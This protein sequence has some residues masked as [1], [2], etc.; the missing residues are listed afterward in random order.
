MSQV[1]KRKRVD[2]PFRHNDVR[3]RMV[4]G[5]YVNCEGR[6]SR[7]V[8]NLENYKKDT[9]IVET[10]N[11]DVEYMEGR[12]KV[13]K[14][15]GTFVATAAVTAA[16]AVAVNGGAV[17]K[18]KDYASNLWNQANSKISQPHV[19]PTTQGGS[20]QVVGY[21]FGDD[22]FVFEEPMGYTPGTSSRIVADSPVMPGNS[23]P[24]T[25]T[26]QGAGAQEEGV[27]GQER[28]NSG[29]QETGVSVSEY[30]NLT[31]Y[32]F[33][34]NEDGTWGF[35]SDRSGRDWHHFVVIDGYHYGND[36]K[37]YD[38]DYK[39]REVLKENANNMNTPR[40]GER[41]GTIA[42]T[43]NNNGSSIT[44]NNG[45]TTSVETGTTE[46]GATIMQHPNVAGV[47]NV[48]ATPGA[49]GMMWGFT[50]DQAGNKWHNFVLIDGV[51]YKDDGNGNFTQ[52]YYADDLYQRAMTQM[53]E[54]VQAG[55]ED[56]VDA[57]IHDFGDYNGDFGQTI[58]Q[59]PNVSGMHNAYTTE[60]VGGLMWGFTEDVAGNIWHNFLYLN[61]VHY[62]DD[63]TGH[64]G[65]AY[66]A[67][68]LYQRVLNEITNSAD[69]GFEAGITGFSNDGFVDH[70]NGGQGDVEIRSY[71]NVTSVGSYAQDFMRGG[72]AGILWGVEDAS[73]NWHNFF[74][75]Q[76]DGLHFKEEGGNYSAHAY[77]V[78]SMFQIAAME[79][80]N[81][82]QFTSSRGNGTR[83]GTLMASTGANGY[84]YEPSAETKAYASAMREQWKKDGA[85]L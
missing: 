47:F 46:T 4:G 15:V 75:R 8:R 19:A 36:G 60:G 27:S 42:A 51:H 18:V 38:V 77:D 78:E 1:K 64:F 10:A 67:D 63:G 71:Q 69:Q 14:V 48:Y 33:Y 49:G 16:V 68:D 44:N 41:T 39:Y 84:K 62:K 85:V 29:N 35:A 61:G 83:V 45:G 11:G 56:F 74:R 34:V 13:G 31:V 12:T 40:G 3:V 37:A 70:G 76:S 81:N 7:P 6:N 79:A 43:E 20:R 9:Y 53:E 58:I 57:S 55:F 59:H 21:D 17:D 26:N 72:E 80:G 28:G 22:D 2:T 73:G 25:N 32:D 52:A 24:R 5:R 65:Q 54:G 66:Y 30:P 23:Q 50:E 82:F